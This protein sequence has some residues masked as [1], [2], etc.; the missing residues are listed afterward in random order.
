MSVSVGFRGGVAEDPKMLIPNRV[1]MYTTRVT[2]AQRAHHIVTMEGPML[3]FTFPTWP[4]CR[5]AFY[6]ES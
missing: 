4:G 6:D 1:S 5:N 2:K 3:Y